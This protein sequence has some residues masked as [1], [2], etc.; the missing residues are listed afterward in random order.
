MSKTM[1]S[2]VMAMFLAAAGAAPEPPSAGESRKGGEP[3]PAKGKA[4]S[5]AKEREKLPK[6]Y[7]DP[8]AGTTAQGQAPRFSRSPSTK[9]EW[10]REVAVSMMAACEQ[11]LKEKSCVPLDLVEERSGP[12]YM[13][14]RVGSMEKVLGGGKEKPPEGMK[15]YLVRAVYFQPLT[16]GFWIHLED[17]NL[18]VSHSCLGNFW[19]P[20]K[21]TALVVALPSEPKT[22]TVRCSMAE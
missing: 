22:V 4:R 21:R 16:G 17:G 6:E 12:C 14:P 13:I 5:T 11:V 10:V 18:L 7:I 8:W 1:T 2:L 20:M 19:T 3:P 9:V 15:P